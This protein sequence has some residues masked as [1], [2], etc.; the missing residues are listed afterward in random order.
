MFAR[1]DGETTAAQRPADLH[2]RQRR[3]QRS[4]SNSSQTDFFGGA[5]SESAAARDARRR[6]RI[7]LSLRLHLVPRPADDR[8][9]RPDHRPAQRDICPSCSPTRTRRAW[10]STTPTCS[11]G[12]NIP[13][14]TASRAARRLNYGV[15]YTA[16][17][18]NGGHANVVGGESIQLAG[19]EFLRDR[20][21]GQHRARIRP[22]QEIFELRRAARRSRRSRRHFSLTSQ[23]AVRQRDLRPDP[24][25]RDRQRQF[26]RLQRP[27][28]DYARY[29]AQPELGWLYQARGPAS[30]TRA[31]SSLD[32]WTVNGSVLF[33]MSRHSTTCPASTRRCF[34]PT[35]LRLRP[36]LRATTARR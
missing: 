4:I 7:P 17:F 23:A 13:A 29:A 22:R 1:L 27:A 35:E 24:P 18:A 28:L 31:T 16:D 2:F 19:T 12:T 21:R 30:P 9:D 10:C 32:H 25:R 8:A 14:T 33:D 36:R 20:R 3:D 26:R 15:Q 5:S 6:A 34:D 11:T